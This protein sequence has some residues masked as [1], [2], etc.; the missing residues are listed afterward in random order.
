MAITLSATRSASLSKGSSGGPTVSP[1]LRKIP[2]FPGHDSALI[3]PP[4][5]G[6]A[7]PPFSQRPGSRILPGIVNFR[8][9]GLPAVPRIF[10]LLIPSARGSRKAVFGDSWLIARDIFFSFYNR[11]MDADVER[12]PCPTFKKRPKKSN[13]GRKELFIQFISRRQ[14]FR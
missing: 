11:Y 7:P 12:L 4:I 14:G 1:D 2:F 10:L 3:P 9:R 8:Q 6:Y 13:P 5:S